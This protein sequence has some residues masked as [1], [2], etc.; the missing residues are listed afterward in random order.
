MNLG[1]S[2]FIDEII[3]KPESQASVGPHTIPRKSPTVIPPIAGSP[4]A[5]Y[6]K[7]HSQTGGSEQS[8]QVTENLHFYPSQ[9]GKSWSL[10]EWEG[11]TSGAAK[12][13]PQLSE[14][15]SPMIPNLSSVVKPPR[16]ENTPLTQTTS[17]EVLEGYWHI[18]DQM[19]NQPPQGQ[20][21]T[22]EYPIVDPIANAW[23]K[24]FPCKTS[25]PSMGWPQRIWMPSYSILTS[26]AE[27]RIT[28]K[29]LKNEAVPF[30]PKR[31]SFVVVYGFGRMHY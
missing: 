12:V 6:A 5:T 16:I 17:L 8:F 31:S 25:Q 13:E 22:L 23:W 14:L 7:I 2:K 28:P 4:S 10:R 29:I 11:E 24:L 1:R 30:Y 18:F 15:G 19:V 20:T 27:D 3:R 9:E 26:C 21:S